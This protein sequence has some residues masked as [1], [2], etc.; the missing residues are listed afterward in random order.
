MNNFQ[1]Q[2]NNKKHEIQQ[3]INQIEETNNEKGNTL[4]R[5]QEQMHSPK[6]DIKH[7]RTNPN[8]NQNISEHI[9]DSYLGNYQT[10]NTFPVKVNDE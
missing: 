1:N 4:K 2:M 9:G 7:Y 6:E 3:N 10:Q 5:I 8:N